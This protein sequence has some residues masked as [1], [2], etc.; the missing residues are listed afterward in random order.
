MMLA[1]AIGGAVVILIVFAD[2]F[3]TIIEPR[4]VER[5][6]NLTTIYYGYAW[7]F[8]RKIVRMLRCKPGQSEAILSKF[9]PA[10]LMG[11][12]VLWVGLLILGFASI[13]FGLGTPLSASLETGFGPYLYLSAETFFTLGYGDMTAQSG[14]GRAIST[15]EA[16]T[17]FGMLA[18][19]VGYLPVLY[20]AFSRREQTALLLDARAGSPPTGG[21]LLRRYASDDCAGLERLLEEFERW[22]AALLE[23][24]LSY[25]MLATYRSQHE[26]LSWLACLTAILDATAFIQA[27]YPDEPVACRSLKRQAALTFALARHVTVDLAYILDIEPRDPNRDRLPP[28]ELAQLIRG[29]EKAGMHV[30]A[31]IGEPL[32]E[33]RERYEPYLTGLSAG[34]LMDMPGWLPR[35]GARDSWETTAWDSVKHF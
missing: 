18:V 9:G 35:D 16:G 1:L 23:T 21:E 14:L 20:Q 31:G 17:G 12:I 34:L 15:I 24:F 30:D 28:E 3:A 19:V 25:P 7:R 4:T 27:G 32:A 33:L 11:L 5:S 8:T 13:Q 29:I 6:F 22:S 26:K 10:S 2:I